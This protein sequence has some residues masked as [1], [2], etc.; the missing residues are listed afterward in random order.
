MLDGDLA[1]TFFGA[2][3]VLQ[4]KHFG[5]VIPVCFRKGGHGVEE[6]VNEAQLRIGQPGGPSGG[7]RG[8]HD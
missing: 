4:A 2:L 6:S 5:T 3:R 8:R 1:P 7:A